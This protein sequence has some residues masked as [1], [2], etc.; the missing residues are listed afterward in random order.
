MYTIVKTQFN[1][2][3]CIGLL[4]RYSGALTSHHL[5]MAEHALV[6]MKYISKTSLEYYRESGLLFLKSYVDSD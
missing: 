3:F 4:K 1:I 6:Y 2:T 5:R